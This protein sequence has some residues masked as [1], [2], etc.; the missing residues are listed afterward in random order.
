MGGAKG[1]KQHRSEAASGKG[2]AQ[3]R[4]SD[5]QSTGKGVEKEGKMDRLRR[6]DVGVSYR[7]MS[8]VVG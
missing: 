1:A 8:K 7:K 6:G 5:V 3:K 4:L 2:R